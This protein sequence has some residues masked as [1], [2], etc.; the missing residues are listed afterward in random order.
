MLETRIS[1]IK[2]FPRT[3]V[4]L[5]NTQKLLTCIFKK[6][7]LVYVQISVI[8]CI[9]LYLTADSWKADPSADNLNAKGNGESVSN[10]GLWYEM[11]S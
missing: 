4:F 7:R 3:P 5:E 6:Y 10:E 8:I 9:W 1:V 2:F 11:G